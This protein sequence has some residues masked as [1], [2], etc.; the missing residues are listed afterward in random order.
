MTEYPEFSLAGIQAEP[1]Y[2]DRE[3]STD[4]ACQPIEEA[5]LKGADLAAFCE[6]WLPGYPFFH[7]YPIGSPLW[8]QAVTAYPL[9]EDSYVTGLVCESYRILSDASYQPAPAD[10][11]RWAVLILS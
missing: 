11:K 9:I 5:N 8:N 6:T 1:V 4:T 10:M 2:F 7:P 3:A